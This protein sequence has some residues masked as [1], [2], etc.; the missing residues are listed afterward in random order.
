M[1]KIQPSADL[2][3]QTAAAGLPPEE[4]DAAQLLIVT[5]QGVSAELC[6]LEKNGSTWSRND[7]IGI[8]AGHIGKN[9]LSTSK[10]EG[11]GCTPAGLFRLGYAF[12]IREQPEI[13]MA[14]RRITKDSYW[15][16]D[17]D[18]R[19]YNMWIEG[20]QYADWTSAERLSDYQREYAYAVI[21]EY[22][23]PERLPG[24][25]SAIFLHCGDR[26][27]SGCIAVPEPELLT[28]LKWLDPSRFPKI[29]I[30]A[31]KSF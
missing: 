28:I 20:R 14:Y 30:K 31:V 16:D 29:L 18:S 13:K 9:G 24:K 27:T 3:C 25:G 22:N 12:G 6:C 10:K 4:I 15:V 23:I 7:T 21:I 1:N 8:I 19:F 26:P 17:P 11:D 2:I 5:A